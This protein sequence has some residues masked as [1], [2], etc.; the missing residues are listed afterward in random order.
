[1]IVS[2]V[3]GTKQIQLICIICESI[4]LA[5]FHAYIYGGLDKTNLQLECMPMFV[6]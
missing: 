1:M 2:V 6:A 4:R 5:L 3:Y